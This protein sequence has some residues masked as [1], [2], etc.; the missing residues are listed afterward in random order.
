METCRWWDRGP[1]IPYEVE[2]YPADWCRRFSVKPGMTGLWQVGGRNQL[3]LEEMVQL[4]LEYAR[5]A[6][7]VAQPAH[8]RQ[9]PLGRATREGGRLM[10]DP[11]NIAVVGYGY[12]GPN[13]VRNVMERPELEFWGLCELERRAARLSSAALSGRPH[14]RSSFEEVLADPAVDAVSIATPPHTHY[15]LV[16]RALEA[17]KHVLVEKPLATP[18]GGREELAE[19]AEREGLVLMPGHT[20][21]YSPAVN[22][23]RELIDSGEL[24]EVYFVTSSRMNLGHLPGGRGRLRPRAA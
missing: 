12:W 19:L 22:K 10:P 18:L 21:L 20:F 8:P 7:L 6:L 5:A 2:Y 17:G 11:I 13:I 3:N 4:D 16:K 23:V 15:A 24:G 14:Q 1:S 9:D